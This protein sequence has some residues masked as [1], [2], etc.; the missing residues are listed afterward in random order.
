MRARRR[1]LARLGVAAVFLTYALVLFH[2]TVF[3]VGGADSSGYMNAARLLSEGRA[4]ACIRGLDR[5][6]LGPEF[7]ESFIP[8][9]FTPGPRPGTMSGSYPPGLPLHDAVHTSDS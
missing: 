5:L 1:L 9:G 6:G 3:A 2:H 7:A 4:T 8:L